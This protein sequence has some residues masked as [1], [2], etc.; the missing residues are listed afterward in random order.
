[1]RVVVASVNLTPAQ[2]AALGLTK[3]RGK[4]KQG[5]SRLACDMRCVA[6]NEIVRMP[7]DGPVPHQK[8]NPTH[9]RY[10]CVLSQKGT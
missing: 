2:A 3:A 9:R 1:M 7:A 5:R 6:C 10:E 4:P 8:E